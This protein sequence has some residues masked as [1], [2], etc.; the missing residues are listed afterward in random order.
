MI[1]GLIGRAVALVGV[2]VLVASGL[3]V[4]YE[5]LPIGPLRY[6]PLLGPALEMLVDGRVDREWRA[7]VELGARDERIAWEEVRRRQ[8]AENARVLKEKQAAIDQLE[9]DYLE[10]RNQRFAEEQ[11]RTELEAALAAS[12]AENAKDTAAPARPAISRRVSRALDKV[13]R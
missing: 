13:G 6:V 11:A 12:E 8:L 2:P 9:R 1:E 10:E 4:F 5:G 7:G 3:I